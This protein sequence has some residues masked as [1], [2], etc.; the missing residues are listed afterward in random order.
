MKVLKLSITLSLLFSF[1][2][3]NESSLESILSQNKQE[4]FSLQYEKNEADSSLLRDSWIAPINLNYN[5]SKGSAFNDDAVVHNASLQ[6]SQPIFQSGG[7]YFGIKYATAL[8]EY[9]NYSVDVAKRKLI[10]DTVSLLMQ[11]KQTSLRVEKQELQIKNAEINLAQKKEQYLNGQLDSGFLNSAIIERNNVISALYDF[12]TAKER[13]ISKFKVVSDME[14]SEA[15]IPHLELINREVFLQNNIVLKMI[16]REIEKNY[17][18]KNVT[19]AKYLP[20]VSLNGS[21]N[22]QKSEGQKFNAG[23]VVSAK[24]VELDYYNYG[25]SATMPLNV[26]TFVDVQSAKVDYLQAKLSLDD[27][28]RELLALFEQVIQNI[29]NFEKKKTLSIENKDIY[30]KLLDETQQLYGIGYKTKYDVEILQNSLDIQDLDTQI[31]D[32][33]AQLELLNLYEMY[34]NEI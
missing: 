34:V 1:V 33:D 7:I 25:L 14:Y 21:Y 16:D 18:N 24:D 27:K 20:R 4:Q 9:S 19:I 26:N 11:I 32:L 29:D 13:L 15:Q 30:T 23:T 2:S 6:I 31:F 8:R 3:A 17:Y 10:K 22:W 28:K 12:E 5:Y